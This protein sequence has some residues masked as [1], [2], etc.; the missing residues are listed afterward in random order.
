[1]MSLMTILKMLIVAIMQLPSQN[2]SLQAIDTQVPGRV[3]E[4]EDDDNTDEDCGQVDFIGWWT[5]SIG[6]H[7]SIPDQSEISIL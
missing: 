6:P 3:T 2:D 4:E 1:M 5:V 7:M